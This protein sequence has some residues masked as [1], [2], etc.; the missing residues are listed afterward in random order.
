[1]VYLEATDI[2]AVTIALTV[3]L[4]LVISA[5]LRNVQL[6]TQ[7]DYWHDQY[8]ELKLETDPNIWKD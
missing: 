3:S 5:S 1:M 8:R 2:I 4:V 6:T 7:R